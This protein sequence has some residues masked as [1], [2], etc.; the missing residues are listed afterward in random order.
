MAQSLRRDDVVWCD[1]FGQGPE[2]LRS[3]RALYDSIVT[4]SCT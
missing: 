2:R 1:E 3:D 4:G